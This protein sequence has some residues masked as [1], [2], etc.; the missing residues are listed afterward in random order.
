MLRVRAIIKCYR[1]ES[2][3]T[4]NNALKSDTTTEI[5]QEIEP[6]IVIYH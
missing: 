6:S 5:N 4:K 1:T 2:F 3:L